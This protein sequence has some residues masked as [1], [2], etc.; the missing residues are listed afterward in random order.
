MSATQV[1][2]T[3]DAMPASAACCDSGLAAA[4]GAALGAAC[5][6]ISTSL[7]RY[8]TSSGMRVGHLHRSLGLSTQ[9][10][11]VDASL[12]VLWLCAALPCAQHPEVRP[13]GW[14]SCRGNIP[15]QLLQLFGCG[16]AACTMHPPWQRQLQ[17]GRQTPQLLQVPH[18]R[19]IGCLLTAAAVI[20]VSS[21]R[22]PALPMIRVWQGHDLV[23]TVQARVAAHT[24]PPLRIVCLHVGSRAELS[25]QLCQSCARAWPARIAQAS[26]KRSSWHLA[27]VDHE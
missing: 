3:L 13:Q 1:Q 27:G 7:G 6:P 9:S 24:R 26:C 18:V 16:K 2:L 17:L 11:A 14:R 10:C 12:T 8:G 15:C 22:R 20:A 4:A 23:Q 19:R 5:G 21:R 25:M